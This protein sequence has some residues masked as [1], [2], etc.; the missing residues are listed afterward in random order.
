M[1]VLCTRPQYTAAT[2][3]TWYSLRAKT[4]LKSRWCQVSQYRSLEMLTPLEGGREKQQLSC[5]VQRF[6]SSKSCHV[7]SRGRNG[8]GLD[9]FLS[10]YVPS[11][12]MCFFVTEET[13]N[14]RLTEF[15]VQYT[16]WFKKMDSILYVHISWT[17][18][19]MWII[20]ITFE[21]GG[22]KFSNTAARALA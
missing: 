20:Y 3:R 11:G 7:F 10:L 15:H 2:V 5:K 8:R 17:I 19:G 18:Q 22:P 14:T 12:L 4:C 13:A 16:V 6:Y 9:L 21:R 1:A